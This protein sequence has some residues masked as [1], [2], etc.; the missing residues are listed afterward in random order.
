MVLLDHI[1]KDSSGAQ[2]DTK[3]IERLVYKQNKKAGSLDIPAT[4]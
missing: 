2:V 3:C 4:I 1:A